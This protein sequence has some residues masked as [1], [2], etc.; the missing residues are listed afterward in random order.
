MKQIENRMFNK[1]W[2]ERRMN[3]KRKEIREQ[4]RGKKTKVERKRNGEMEVK[5]EKK[6]QMSDGDSLQIKCIQ[7][8]KHL[9]KFKTF[10]I[11]FRLNTEMVPKT[12]RPNILSHLRKWWIIKKKKKSSV[13][14]V[15]LR[16]IPLIS[17]HDAA[18]AGP[19]TRRGSGSR[20]TLGRKAHSGAE[21]RALE[22][23]K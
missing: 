6:E 2:K 8:K 19:C 7:Y 18:A 23:M 15:L 5:Q 1:H 14:H 12:P 21:G 13:Q 22:G 9:H 16:T 20:A 10:N 11:H 4:I 3:K 17:H